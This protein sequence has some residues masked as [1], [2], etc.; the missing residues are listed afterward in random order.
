MGRMSRASDAVLMCGGEETR[1]FELLYVAQLMWHTTYSDTLVREL[2][3]VRELLLGKYR[4][5]THASLYRLPSLVSYEM[6]IGMSARRKGKQ[7][8]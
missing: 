1:H 7:R 2:S 4:R 8:T 5:I 6:K 3:L